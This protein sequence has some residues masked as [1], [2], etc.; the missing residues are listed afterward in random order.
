MSTHVILVVDD[1]PTI[2]RLVGLALEQ[3]GYT[4]ATAPDG[5]AGLRLFYD[6]NGGVDLVVTDF[7]M[8]RCN[9]IRWSARWSGRSRS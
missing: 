5:E 1:E 3:A 4:V 8:P 7:L 6:R 9:G 2:V